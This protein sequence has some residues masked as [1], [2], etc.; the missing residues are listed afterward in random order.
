MDIL[1]FYGLLGGH[2]ILFEAEVIS[3]NIKNYLNHIEEMLII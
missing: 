1:Q 3:L 2:I